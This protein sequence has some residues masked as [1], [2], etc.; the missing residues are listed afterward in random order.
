[1]TQRD[2]RA[3]ALLAVL[4]SLGPAVS[5]AQV[6]SQRGVSATVPAISWQPP[7]GTAAGAARYRVRVLPV[8]GADQ[9][10]RLVWEKA[11]LATPAVQYAGPPLDARRSYVW[12]MEALDAQ[13]RTIAGGGGILG[14]GLAP[15]P[16]NF[17]SLYVFPSATKV[18]LGQTVT[19]S[20]FCS[21]SRA[22][23]RSTPFPMG[24]PPRPVPGQGASW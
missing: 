20:R 5:L 21:P 22:V 8:E 12:T 14:G 4:F 7:R 11:D 9:L 2:R 18:C 24:R 15:P 13:G 16:P 23:L 3:V 6:Q 10:G 17:C 19:L 1:M